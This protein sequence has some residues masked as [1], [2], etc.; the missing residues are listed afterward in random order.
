[1][2]ILLGKQEFQYMNLHKSTGEALACHLVMISITGNQS[3]SSNQSMSSGIAACANAVETNKSKEFEKYAVIT[4][5][6]A[7]VVGN[8][9]A[10]GVGFFGPGKMPDNRLENRRKRRKQ[11]DQEETYMDNVSSGAI[12]ERKSRIDDVQGSEMQLEDDIDEDE[13]QSSNREIIHDDGDLSLSYYHKRDD[14]DDD[15]DNDDRDMNRFPMA[16]SINQASI[17]IDD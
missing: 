13:E 12:E 11:N 8:S 9:L 5:R 17:D 3:N 4:I 2:A 10:Y 16:Y 7:S 1:M 14:D 6:S 15:D